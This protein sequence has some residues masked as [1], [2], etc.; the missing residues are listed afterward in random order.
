M[1]HLRHPMLL[2]I[3]RH[4]FFQKAELTILLEQ[5]KYSPPF[6]SF[7][8]CNYPNPIINIQLRQDCAYEA[9]QFNFYFNLIYYRKICDFCKN[10]NILISFSG[11]NQ[12]FNLHASCGFF[13]L[14]IYIGSVAKISFINQ[15]SQKK[16]AV[17]KHWF[18][19]K[20]SISESNH[21]LFK[22]KKRQQKVV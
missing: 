19:V 1:Q 21:F 9:K 10:T 8:L 17:N 2:T 12:F 3:N 4:G 14:N 11:T 22:K 18:T 5:Y 20:P 16:V 15:K 6:P 13:F 7:N